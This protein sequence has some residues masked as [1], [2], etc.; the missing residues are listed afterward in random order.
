MGWHQ[1][2]S[3]TKHNDRL[4]QT[5][6]I[7]QSVVPTFPTPLVFI[8][9]DFFPLHNLYS[10]DWR[11]MVAGFW[12]RYLISISGPWQ[13]S[14][15]NPYFFCYKTC[16]YFFFDLDMSKQLEPFCSSSINVSQMTEFPSFLS[17]LNNILC[18]PSLPP[19]LSL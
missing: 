11:A 6:P 16:T 9:T 14:K 18:S 8:T 15:I 12:E 4:P 19:S 2:D 3:R 13:F 5:H 1:T 7:I 17:Y 10:W